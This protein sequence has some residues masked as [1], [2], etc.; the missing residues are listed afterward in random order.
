MDPLGLAILA[1]APFLANVLSMLAG[2]IGP[3]SPGQLAAMRVFGAACVVA[4]VFVPVPAFMMI[5][6]GVFWLTYSFGTPFQLR[7]SAAIYPSRRRGRLLGLIGTGRAAAGGI[8][9]LVAG[10]LGDRI[11]DIPAIS[12]IGLVGASLIVASAGIHAPAAADPPHF[13]ARA[14]LRALGA[15][16]ALRTAVAAQAF[17]GGGL[18]AAV[19][20]YALVQVD[21]LQLSLGEVGFLGL[22]GAAATTVSY[23]AWGALADKRGGILLLRGGGILGLAS[24]IA[25]AVAP[26]VALLW[27]AAVC[28]GLASAG[29]DIGLQSVLIA[30]AESDER[31]MVM[32]GWNAVTGLRGLIAPFI[33]SAVVQL[34][35]LDVTTTLLAC[36]VVTAAGVV[37]FL[38]IETPQTAR[39]SLPGI[40]RRLALLRPSA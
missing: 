21:R 11:G 22:L 39:A 37:M 9:V 23:L 10:L 30:G 25:Y 36:S 33:A 12:V 4:L 40:R 20:L 13:S 27:I 18:I 14:S 26:S 3:R 2:R 6:A 5:V 32:A 8:A 28:A 16:P 35:L 24:L 17:Y 38:R 31:A 7:L 29:I 15:R 1:A 34:H 19:P